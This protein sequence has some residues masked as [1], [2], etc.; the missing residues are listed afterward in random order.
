MKW[1]FA[2]EY[3]CHQNRIH[4]TFRKRRKETSASH[5]ICCSLQLRQYNVWITWTS[6]LI[7]SI[8]TEVQLVFY[9]LYSK[10]DT[11]SELTS[12]RLQ[13]HACLQNDQCQVQVD[14]ALRR[15][16][17]HH[18]TYSSYQKMTRLNMKK[19]K[20]TWETFRCENS[21]RDK[22]H[23]PHQVNLSVF[24]RWIK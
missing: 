14:A 15:G 4:W 13:K 7:F 9:V 17:P 16:R 1:H 21:L 11:I 22:Q 5:R 12:R 8:Q 19:K 23:Q 3:P 2:A 10:P 6:S 24:V 18:R 20:W